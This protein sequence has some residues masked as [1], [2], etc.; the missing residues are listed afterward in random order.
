MFDAKQPDDIFSAV[1]KAVP[2]PVQRPVAPVTAPASPAPAPAAGA[3]LPRPTAGVP[4]PVTTPP[5]SA[6]M[7]I[8]QGRDFAG[9]GHHWW[10]ILPILGVVV[11]AVA[12]YMLY[13]R[14]VPSAAPGDQLPEVTTPVNTNQPITPTDQTPT[15]SAPDAVDTV[16]TTPVDSDLDGLDDA[17]E[18]QYGT[19]PSLADS[20]LDGLFDKEEIQVYRTDPLKADSDGD[21]FRDGEE[22][23]N[24]YNPLGP[25]RLFE[26]PA[27]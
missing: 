15:N 24:G 2:E 11:A 20:D 9:G 4:A 12:G 26:V 14:Y 13:Q 3:T 19:N 10:V 23:R 21:S 8:V 1:D 6:A 27:Q 17:A 18:A 22:V 16:V 7:D 5:P 25:G